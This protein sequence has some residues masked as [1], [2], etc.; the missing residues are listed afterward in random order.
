MAEQV[1]PGADFETWVGFAI[2]KLVE[3]LYNPEKLQ[4]VQ[5]ATAQGVAKGQT[6]AAGAAVAASPGYMEQVGQFA[7]KGKTEIERLLGTGMALL[8]AEILGVEVSPSKLFA[9]T[10]DPE[11]SVLGEAIGGVAMNM[12]R[13]PAGPLEPG[14]EGAKRFIGTLSHIIVHGWAEGIILERMSALGGFAHGAEA[15][16]DLGKEIV[17]GLG[18]SRIARTALRPL[19]RATIA[20]PLEWHANKTYR[21]A[22]VAPATAIGQFQSGL[23]SLE[24]ML[25]EL[26]RAG[27]DDTRIT[28]LINEQR[29]LLSPAD[30]NQLVSRGFWTADEG[31]QHLRLIGYDAEIA[32][33]VLR[34]EGTRRIEQ[35]DNA[36]ASALI[37]AYAQRDI[38]DA[39]IEGS[40]DKFDFP[41][42]E[43]A[44]VLE[45]AHTRRALNVHQLSPAEA[46]RC[47]RKGI[48]SVIDYREALERAG[49]DEKAVTALELL[50]RADLDDEHSVE[51]HRAQL[52][53]ERAAEKA[54]RDAE[55]AA[56]LAE[57]DA[58]RT[59][60]RRGSEAALEAA[61]IRGL[62]SFDRVAEVYRLHNDEDTVR[63]LLELLEGKRQDY[64]AQQ[65]RA[66]DAAQRVTARGL[67]IADL[68]DAVLNDVLTLDQ[69]RS[70]LDARGVTGDDV[71][72]LARTLAA[73]K[74]ARDAAKDA[75]GAAGAVAKQQG[76]DLDRFEQL[77]RRGARTIPQYEAL[78]RSLN[79]SDAAI[80][81]L[82]ELLEL[83]IA[84][85]EAARQAREDA[86]A[87]LALKGLSL[88]EWRRAVILGLKSRD[89][90]E[91]F[92]RAQ[93][94]TVDRQTLLLAELDQA[95]AEAEAARARRLEAD[96][97]PDAR[98][99][100]L[101]TIAR[102][103]RLGVVTPAVYRQRLTAAGYTDDDVAIE[104]EL[105]T[106][107]IAD[108][109]AA[110]QQRQAAPPASA[111]AG[112]SLEQLARAVRR[113]LKTLE[114]FRARAFELGLSPDAVTTQIRVLGDE[115]KE[116]E[117][118]KQRRA[119]IGSELDAK[120]IS[121][122][123]LEQRVLS[124]VDTMSTF[125]KTLVA[126]GLEP[127]DAA[128][129]GSLLGDEVTNG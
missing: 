99:L 62:V 48:L 115:L 60:A 85:D 32:D 4:R 43:K 116:T 95:V 8:V 92:L 51:Q 24:Q 128:L 98:A 119:A 94:F 107:E 5:E 103:A 35:Q 109:Q 114:D 90:F 123:D 84:D 72:V 61:A 39:A 86:A 96:A 58:R 126:A 30:V 15:L 77:V 11:K 14:D 29:K 12:F 78:L 36:L 104:L 101:S 89:E 65:Q 10:A 20:T 68:E 105:L 26:A 120:S 46:E 102:A 3:E 63:I 56:K 52:I 21:P 19:V 2:G 113:G 59:D 108:V 71:D 44:F 55:R 79:R 49:Y 40:L 47:V 27:Y 6:I 88:D 83:K 91:A 18:L 76:I 45:L 50:L 80:A 110:R 1:G 42:T 31:R 33:L 81:D 67:S 127:E 38:E 54:Q 87:E 66:A 7:E 16:A 74:T 28:A 111:P 125:V 121:L 112:L 23:W 53:A 122:T 69:Y 13:G 70:A 57:A 17:Q 97:R 22:L 34:I 82:V 129:L 118:A 37:T 100:P 124:G 93:T 25:E 106:T 73:K 64:L 117:L 75:R 9:D 41:A